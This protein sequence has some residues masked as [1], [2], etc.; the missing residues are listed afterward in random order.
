VRAKHTRVAKLRARGAQRRSRRGAKLF[1][2]TASL[3]LSITSASRARDPDR[4]RP[5]SRGATG[6]GQE[7]G[8]SSVRPPAGA[9]LATRS[10]PGQVTCQSVSVTSDLSVDPAP[11]LTFSRR[12]TCRWA[13]G[14]ARADQGGRS[15]TR[16]LPASTSHAG[17][18]LGLPG[19]RHNPTQGGGAVS[20]RASRENGT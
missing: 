8:A 15:C 5:V 17:H 6:G 16:L 7:P 10:R 9:R 13:D 12:E 4:P 3:L 2:G 20:R 11:V 1:R 14:R 18:C 19:E